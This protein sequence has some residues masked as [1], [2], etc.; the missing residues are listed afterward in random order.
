MTSFICYASKQAPW[1]WKNFHGKFSRKRR[2]PLHFVDVSSCADFIIES[3]F[4]KYIEKLRVT[5]ERKR[6]ELVSLKLLISCFPLFFRAFETHRH[7]VICNLCMLD[8]RDAQEN[9]DIYRESVVRNPN[10]V[11]SAEQTDTAFI[12]FD[13][14][15]DC[16]LA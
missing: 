13:T 14:Y 7:S 9:H 15:R 6:V 11:E 16:V 8:R 1:E 12:Y 5:W 10:P 4:E 3:F 2:A